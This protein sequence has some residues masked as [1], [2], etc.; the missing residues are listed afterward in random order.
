M[1]EDK[2]AMR[3]ENETAHRLAACFDTG[4]CAVLSEKQ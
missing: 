4:V 2:Q 1:P 3:E